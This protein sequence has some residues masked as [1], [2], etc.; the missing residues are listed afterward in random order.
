MIDDTD[1]VKRPVD[2]PG[3]G[4]FHTRHNGRGR[5]CGSLFWL[6]SLLCF[7]PAPLWA[8]ASL[9]IIYSGNLDGELE[10]CG[11]SAEGNFGGIKR[12]ATL[13]QRLRA[14]NPNLVLLSA[15]GLLSADG[16]G[17]RLKGEYI[18][19]GMA[20]LDY[21]AIAVQWRDLAYGE[22]FAASVALPWVLSNS[23]SAI[24]GFQPQRLIERD[25]QRIA[26]FSWLDSKGSPMRQ[27]QG[28]H[29]LVDEAPAALR[30]ALRQAHAQGQL[31]V[32]ATDL[33]GQAFA[34]AVGLADVDI[35]I[36]KA[37]YEVY[38]E[39]R[40]QEG[41]LIVQPGSRGMRLGRLDLSVEGG[42]I[43]TWRHAILPMPNTIPDAPQLAAWYDEYNARVKADYLQRVE[44]RKTQ[45]AGASPFAGEAVCQTCHAAQHQ[46]WF[47]TAHA[48]AYEKLEAVSKAFDPACIRCHVV[49]FDQPGGFFD[50]NITAHLMGVQCESC[51]GAGQAHAAAGGS[52]PLAN[53]GWTP[54]QMCGQCHVQ[55]H[56]PGFVFD[57]Y[58]PKI[59]H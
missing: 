2:K 6:V 39:P 8:E 23:R 27:M 4:R 15:G 58:W 11:C 56:S 37:A 25:A 13:L 26:Y 34:E 55:K 24:A 16:P 29:G 38:G 53:A 12:R 7:A 40:M 41:T 48:T 45:T 3:R 30:E 35:L 50:I 17:D 18:L 47:D 42:R 28:E 59:A 32:L 1:G 10:P 52:Q 44:L 9:T 36:E 57:R 49:G 46:V 43:R 20:M 51:H 14:E 22:A 31:T 54:Q 19:K 33:S 5:C 21:D